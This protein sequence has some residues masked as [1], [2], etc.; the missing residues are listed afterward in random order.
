MLSIFA[1]LL[2]ISCGLGLVSAGLG[3]LVA[4]FADEATLVA[5]HVQIGQEAG[6]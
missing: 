1:D 4:L 2:A 3:G 5:S 6:Q